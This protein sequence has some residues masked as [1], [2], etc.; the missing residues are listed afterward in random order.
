MII[1]LISHA[2]Q[3]EYIS[4]LLIQ[5]MASIAGSVTL[6][7]SIMLIVILSPQNTYSTYPDKSR[8]DTLFRQGVYLFY[9]KFNRKGIATCSDG[10][11]NVFANLAAPR[12]LN[13][14]VVDDLSLVGMLD[15]LFVKN[16]EGHTT[17]VV[18][19]CQ[20]KGFND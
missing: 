2:G 7:D 1:F 8:V 20:L 6:L 3:Y 12:V 5:L 15:S 19:N 9:S 14:G 13:L 10:L 16:A 18:R 4:Q 17:Q 11:C